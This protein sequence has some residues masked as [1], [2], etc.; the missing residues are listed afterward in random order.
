MK[1]YIPW[2]TLAVVL[3]VAF[4]AV[5]QDEEPPKKEAKEVEV[6]E[7]ET[8]DAA[9]KAPEEPIPLENPSL[10][11]TQGKFAV[12]VIHETKAERFFEGPLTG[13]TAAKKLASLGLAPDGG[14]RTDADLTRA[15]LEAAY[16]RLKA[17]MSASEEAEEGADAGGGV[18]DMTVAE[19]ID[20]IVAAMKKVFTR[21]SSE[22]MPVSPTGWSWK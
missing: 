22:R 10:G 8:E 12:L 21:I 6:A 3:C 7:P 19:L 2:F 4:G 13:A 5:A 11:M 20:E 1:R 16:V 17:S 9:P 14:W 18:T 15:D